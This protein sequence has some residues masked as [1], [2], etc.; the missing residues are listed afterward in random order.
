MN[1]KYLISGLTCMLAGVVLIVL[2]GAFSPSAHATIV[3][4]SM[5]LEGAGGILVGRSKV[6]K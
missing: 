1:V 2:L 3:T 5:L 6:G 4:F